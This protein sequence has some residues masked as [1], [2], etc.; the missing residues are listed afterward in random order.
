MRV[1]AN[2]EHILADARAQYRREE[3]LAQQTVVRDQRI[4]RANE[5]KKVI[6]FGSEK[7]FTFRQTASQRSPPALVNGP[8]KSADCHYRRCNVPGERV[9]VTELI[10]NLTRLIKLEPA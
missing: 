5:N 1:R 4:Q 7:L 10:E 2:A 3:Q 9:D 6:K 8:Y